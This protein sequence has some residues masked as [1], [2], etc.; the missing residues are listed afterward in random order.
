MITFDQ[1]ISEA[2]LYLEQNMRCGKHHVEHTGNTTYLLDL[3]SYLGE[4]DKG[5][6]L[7]ATLMQRVVQDGELW[8]FYPGL[9]NPRNMSNNVIDCGSCVDTIARFLRKHRDSFSEAEHS[10]Y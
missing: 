3:Y 1:M 6:Q 4:I 2:A 7:V 9:K 8:I 5:K 10:E